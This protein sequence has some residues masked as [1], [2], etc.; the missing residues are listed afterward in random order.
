MS[1]ATPA[2]PSGRWESI[3]PSDSSSIEP[4]RG[5]YLGTAGDVRIQDLAGN[6]VVISSL[7]AGVVHPVQCQQVFATNTTASDILGVY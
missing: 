6:D 7:Q 4:T 1:D 5:L 2:G 3:T